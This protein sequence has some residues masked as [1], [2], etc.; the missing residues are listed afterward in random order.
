[1]L[2]YKPQLTD[3]RQLSQATKPS[4]QVSVVHACTAVY[5]CYSWHIYIYLYTQLILYVTVLQQ[6]TISTG[7]PPLA[8][9]YNILNKCIYP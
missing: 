1:M 8:S 2:G 7:Q 6:K 3:T 9:G 5:M 4:I